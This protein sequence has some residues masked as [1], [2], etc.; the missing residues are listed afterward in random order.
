MENKIK[1]LHVHCYLL[2]F[3]LLL[4]LLLL[5]III[6]MEFAS[7]KIFILK[8]WCYAVGNPSYTVI[9]P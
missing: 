7:F 9:V 8:Q 3:L 5:T 1:T 6:T 4:L 2:L